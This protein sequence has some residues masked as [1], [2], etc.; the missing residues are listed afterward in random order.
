MKTKAKSRLRLGVLAAVLATAGFAWADEALWQKLAKE[1]DLVVLMRHTEPS[2]GDPLAWDESGNC[3]GESMLTEAGKAHAKPADF[4]QPAEETG[5]EAEPEAEAVAEA[6]E[7]EVL[8]PG[9]KVEE[10]EPAPEPQP[11]AE[12]AE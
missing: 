12:G 2:G 4:E 9:E 3:A 7:H 11:V 10:P 6:P 1:S 8:S 5:P